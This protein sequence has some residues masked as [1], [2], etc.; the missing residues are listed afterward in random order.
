MLSIYNHDRDTVHLTYVYPVVS[1]RAGG[2]S[3]GINLNP[4]WVNVLVIVIL[5][6]ASNVVIIFV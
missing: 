1:R 2:V 6:Y 5:G 4:N 3:L